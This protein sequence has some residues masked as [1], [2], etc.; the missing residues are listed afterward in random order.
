MLSPD[1]GL[2]FSAWSLS[3]L[4]DYLVTTGVVAAISPESVRQILRAAGV[5]WQA[6]KT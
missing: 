2:A 4:A 5:S 1:L 3:K 6:A